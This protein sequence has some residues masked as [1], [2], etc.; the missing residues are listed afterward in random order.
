[1]KRTLEGTLISRTHLWDK[2][3]VASGR[4]LKLWFLFIFIF[5]LG[6]G[7]FGIQDSGSGCG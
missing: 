2:L 5:F 1:M 7:G 6:G 4:G 3:F